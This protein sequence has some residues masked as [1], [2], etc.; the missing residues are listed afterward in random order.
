MKLRKRIQ[1]S[2]TLESVLASILAGYVRL[3]LATGKWQ[4]NGLGDLER[5]L[6]D[7]PVILVMWHSRLMLSGPHWPKQWCQIK[8]IHDTAPAGR[9][10][11]ATMKKFGLEPIAV[12]S[13]KTNLSITRTVMREV[14]N[15]VSIGLAADGPNG[16]VRHSKP[17]AIGWTRATGRPVFV[18]T[19]ASRRAFRLGS[20]DRLLMPVPFASGTYTFKRWGTEIPRGLDAQ[21]YRKMT[22]ELDLFLDQV[23]QETNE[24]ADLSPDP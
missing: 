14:S 15:G 20:W 8:A 13:S 6:E 5:A 21:A 19:W 2:K 22:E 17:A 18:Y 16:P 10:A 3:C 11:G 1:N 7:G 12:S 24:K 23:T 4:A 9:L